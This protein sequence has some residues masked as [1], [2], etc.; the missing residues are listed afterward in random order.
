MSARGGSQRDFFIS[1]TFALGAA[2]NQRQA[3]RK[4]IRRND[5]DI[6]IALDGFIFNETELAREFGI[7]ERAGI[8]LL[9]HLYKLLGVSCISKLQGNYALVI[10]DEP[11]ERL[12]LARDSI[13]SRPLHY[14]LLK[15]GLGFASEPGGFRSFDGFEAHPDFR[16]I[17]NLLAYTYVPPPKTLLHGVMQV[18]HGQSIVFVHGKILSECTLRPPP[19]ATFSDADENACSAELERL[20]ISSVSRRISLSERTGLLLSGGVDTAAIVGA[21]AL[22]QRG[23]PKTFTVSFPDSPEVDESEDARWTARHFGTEHTEVEVTSSC[24][25]FL[26]QIAAGGNLASVNP[27]SLVSF[28]LFKQIGSCVDTVLCGDGGNDLLGG[29]YRYNQVLTY[30]ES[31][32]R[33]S[34][35]GALIKHG[36]QMYHRLKGTFL[37]PLIHKAARVFFERAGKN[38][39]EQDAIRMGRA[40]FD[41]IARYYID[42]DVFWR[43]EDKQR[44]YSADFS[45]EL[46]EHTTVKFL[47]TLL[48]YDRGLSI[49]QQ[50]PFVRMNSFIP[51]I[52]VFYL[53]QTA[54]ANR[55]E[56]L[57]P[58]LDEEL[59]EFMYQVPFEFV[60]GKSFRF[61]M[62]RAFAGRIMPAELFKR[63]TKGFRL[64]I[65]IW[66][67][68]SDWKEVVYAHLGDEA[69]KKR[70]W[71]SPSYVRSVLDRFYS[72]ESY[73]R[74]QSLGNVTSLGLLI[75][76]LVALESWAQQNLDAR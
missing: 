75:W 46:E 15:S 10:W 19:P 35:Q 40:Q 33:T 7:E 31:C 16:S 25:D 60:Y 63:P 51:Y 65:E 73:R 56:A 74:E 67:R 23:R 66:M 30:S 2:T 45:A 4:L 38:L 21:S 6:C 68:R 71:F 52:A 34:L 22:A 36:R 55:I 47:E 41:Q 49:F 14:I 3:E 32:A 57:F 42:S 39:S 11:E 48:D 61:L 70:G 54:A 29:H 9:L 72:G 5:D 27:T 50:L 43:S 17:D 28:S 44:L 18:R 76:T 12:V 8:D 1:P 69:V 64:P 37:E 59:I 53:E 58:L 24:I 20:L 62:K 26:P 13:G